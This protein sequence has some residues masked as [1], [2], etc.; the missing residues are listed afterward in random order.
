MVSEEAENQIKEAEKKLERA[1]DLLDDGYFEESA[2]TSYYSMY[3]GAKA[4][5]V[6]RDSRPKTHRGVIRELY[7]KYVKDEEFDEG[8]AGLL[9]R[10]LQI[11][12]R[13]DYEVMVDIGA[14]TAK[15]ALIDAEKFLDEVKRV[16]KR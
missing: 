1:R 2:R 7:T 15:I 16:L 3:H 9:A 6:L 11:R 13:I 4:M 10:D 8:I 14:E 12:L 5:L